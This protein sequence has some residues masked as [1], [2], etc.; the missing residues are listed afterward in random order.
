[1]RRLAAADSLRGSVA[2][3]FLLLSLSGCYTTEPVEPPRAVDVGSEVR[4]VYSAGGAIGSVGASS[5]ESRL[6]E[7]RVLSVGPDT[8]T[9][10]RAPAAT[11]D[12][13]DTLRLGQEDV[14]RIERKRIDAGSTAGLFAG[15]LAGLGLAALVLVSGDAGGGTGPDPGQDPIDAV[16]I[17]FP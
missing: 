14:R 4:V 9:L 8:L 3:A 7:G 2:V 5:A 1:M 17:P 11:F 10:L 12:R 16:R 15:A 6:A 13:A